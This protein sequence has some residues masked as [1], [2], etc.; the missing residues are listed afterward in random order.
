MLDHHRIEIWHRERRVGAYLK[1]VS[2]TRCHFYIPGL[3]DTFLERAENGHW[4]FNYEIPAVDSLKFYV[5]M[6]EV[7]QK[8][9]QYAEHQLMVLL[10]QEML[11]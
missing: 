3:I 9:E 5:N 6:K 7:Y 1:L 10:N 4:L 2:N 8:V 11:S